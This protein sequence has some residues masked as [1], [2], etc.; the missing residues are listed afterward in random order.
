M[1]S[2]IFIIIF[3]ICVFQIKA[4]DIHYSQYDCSPLNL[5]PA[6]CGDIDCD[7]RL[8]GN[9]RTQWRSITVPYQTFSGSFD[10]RINNR[11]IRNNLLGAGLQFNSDKAGDSDFGTSQLHLVFASH[12]A[13]LN[14][15]KLTLSAGI[16]VAYNRNTINYNNLNFGS[17]Y[18]GNRFDS[19][20]PYDETFSEDNFSYFDFAMGVHLKYMLKQS[21][22]VEAGF[23]YTHINKPQKSFFSDNLVELDRKFNFYGSTRINTKKNIS[24]LPGFLI[25]NQGR[26]KEIDLGG[27]IRFR[28]S[29]PAFRALYAGGWIRLKDAGIIKLGLAYKNYNIGISYDINTSDL[30]IASNG[31]GGLEISV[32]GVFCLARKIIIP[33]T[34][35][36]PDFI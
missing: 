16:D 33:N 24:F 27:L 14:N 28:L 7:F 6:L 18:N 11:F 35:I 3:L 8:A 22:P 21:M 29:N 25:M 17:Q 19:S 34:K 10:A 26:Y 4:Q 36:C 30:K 31:Y 2:N 12:Q 1:N 20:L 23:A 32:S 15:N 5:N 9:E 13:F